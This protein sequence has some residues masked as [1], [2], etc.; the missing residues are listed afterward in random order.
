MGPVELYSIGEVAAILGV[1]AHTIRAWERRHGV[2]HPQRTR[3][4]QRRY[5]N[6]DVERLRRVK[7][8]VEVQGLSLRLAVQAASGDFRP[9]P[10]MRSAPRLSRP[11]ETTPPSDAGLLQAVAQVLRQL[12]FI[13]GPDGMILEANVAVAKALKTVRQRLVGR[14]F[15]DLV[16]PFDRSKAELMYRPTMRS[17]ADWELN[18][19]VEPGPRMFSFQCWPI[20]QHGA[21]LLALFGDEMFPGPTQRTVDDLSPPGRVELAG[22][23]VHSRSTSPDALQTLVDQ[24]PFGVVVVTVGPRPRVVY[25]NSRSTQA[26]GVSDRALI[27]RP[28]AE[29]F[30]DSETNRGLAEA[31]ASRT[32]RTVRASAVDSASERGAPILPS[33]L[34]FRPLFSSSQVVTSVLVVIEDGA[35]DAATAQELESLVADRRFETASS[36]GELAQVGIEHLA[37]L[38]PDVDFAIALGDPARGDGS[39]P[40]VARSRPWKPP[41]SS[42]GRLAL[43]TAVAS[44]ATS[45]STRIVVYEESGQVH[46]VTAAPLY[47][48]AGTGTP[49]SLGTLAW[50]RPPAEPLSRDVLQTIDAFGAR[51]SLATELLHLRIEARR[52]ASQLDAIITAASVVRDS[53]PATGLGV[54]FLERLARSID[55]DVATIGRGRGRRIVLDAVYF[56]RRIAIRP[57]DIYR[58]DGNFVSESVRSG[59]PTATS[60]FDWDKAPPRLAKGLA[61]IKHGLSIPLKLAGRVVAVIVLLRAEDR[62]FSQDDV[63]LVQMLSSVALLAVTLGRQHI[64]L[65]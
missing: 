56:R 43:E 10:V 42:E 13:I 14:R 62:Q 65:D 5:R 41:S 58:L 52:K 17:L 51:L 22:S 45:R 34:S 31:I 15:V 61:A 12:I 44:A 16:D 39:F 4:R 27:G 28:F 8:A 40:I 59:E 6:E 2:V 54:R 63:E 53:D 30:P 60:T 64:R 25:A 9:T 19:L 57:G 20:N 48:S 26:L 24:L 3:T 55:A 47:S 29:L 35:Q 36:V 38:I 46:R 49:R 33:N 1:S 7:R 32:Q 18:L 11:L 23:G 37:N 50:R 21:T